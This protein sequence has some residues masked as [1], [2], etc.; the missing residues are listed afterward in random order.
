MLRNPLSSKRKQKIA[1]KRVEKFFGIAH[2]SKWYLFATY[3]RKLFTAV[4]DSELSC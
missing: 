1:V 4:A 2:A 3:N